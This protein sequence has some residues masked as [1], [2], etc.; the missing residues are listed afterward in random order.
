MKHK[1]LTFEEVVEDLMPALHKILAHRLIYNR[2]WANVKVI[3]GKRNM[4]II[5]FEPK[6]PTDHSKMRDIKPFNIDTLT[7]QIAVQYHKLQKDKKG[8]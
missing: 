8:G 6:N 2:T 1:E 7:H 3:T 4:K 5:W